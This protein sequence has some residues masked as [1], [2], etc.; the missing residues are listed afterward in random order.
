MTCS[1]HELLWMTTQDANAMYFLGICHEH[2]MGTVCNEAKAAKLYRS[3]ASRGH[4]SAL[5]N[6]AVFFENGIGGTVH[7]N[8]L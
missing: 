3:A 1:V 5:Y 4:V 6:L 2:G 8:V 7:Q